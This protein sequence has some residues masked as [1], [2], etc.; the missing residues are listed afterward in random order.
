MAALV[1]AGLSIDP[2]LLLAGNFDLSCREQSARAMVHMAM[3][4]RPSAVYAAND[5]TALGVLSEL[6]RSGWEVPK[7]IAVCGFGD[8][9]LA[10]IVMPSLL[11]HDDVTFLEVQPTLIVER[12]TSAQI[13]DQSA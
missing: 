5:E 13:A 3:E 6:G 11:H 1:E 10:Q 2:N 9:P 4:Y 7:D 8:I 12:G